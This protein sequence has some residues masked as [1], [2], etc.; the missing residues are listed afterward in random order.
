M[1]SEIENFQKKNSDSSQD[2]KV[3]LFPGMSKGSCNF[4]QDAAIKSITNIG[5]AAMGA[6]ARAQSE[7]E[8]SNKAKKF[9]S[10]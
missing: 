3:E 1:R 7:V 2:I 5:T 6:I 9:T 10:S 4:D 8:A